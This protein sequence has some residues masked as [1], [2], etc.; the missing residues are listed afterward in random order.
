MQSLGAVHLNGLRAVEAVART[1]RLPAAADELG[2]SVSAVS[3]QVNRTERQLGRALFVRQARGMVPTEFGAAF[4]ARLTAGFRELSAAVQSARRLDE[5]PL[6]VSVAPAFASRWL[7]A[8]LSRLFERHPDILVRIDASSRIADLEESDI[9]VAIRFGDGSWPDVEARLL[10]AQDIYPVAAPSIG[11]RILSLEDLS[12]ATVI[13][14]EDAMFGWDDWFAAAGQM[15]VQL[16][17]GARF[18]DPLLCLDAAICGNGVMLAWD[19]IAGDAVADGRLV[20]P[21]GTRTPSGL[22][23]WLCARKGGRAP[24]KVRAFTAWIGE[25]IRRPRPAP[26]ARSAPAS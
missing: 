7:I 23:Y 5:G 10:V 9:D 12:A 13:I 1:G 21:F 19:L 2:V 26:P 4:C 24:R 16:Q 8:R 3:Q 18:S 15:P 22:G 25:E 11:G 6:L 17:C 20:A 14:D